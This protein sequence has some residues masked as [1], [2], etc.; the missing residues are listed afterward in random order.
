MSEQSPASDAASRRDFLKSSSALVGATVA[1]GLAAPSVHAAG[2]DVIRIGLIG[3][4]GRGS[5]AA[6]QAMEA[7]SDCKL[8]AMGDVFA[9][10]LVSSRERLRKIGKERFAVE[11]KDCY[12]GLDAYKNVVDCGVDVVLMGTPPGFRPVHLKYAV[13]QGKHVFAEKPVA[14]DGPGVRSVLATC[15]EAK[16]K[17]LSIVSG[18]CWRYHKAV[19]E[20]MQRVQDGQIGRIISLQANYNTRRPRT[21]VPRAEGLSDLEFQLRNWYF[22]AW[23]SGDFNVEQHV[24]TL[25]KMAWVLHDR[26]PVKCIGSGGRQ[27]IAELEPGHIY[28]HHAVHYEFASDDGGPIPCYSYCR[29][30]SGTKSQ[31]EGYVFGTEGKA[32]LLANHLF[33]HKGGTVWKFPRPRR[34]EPRINMYQQEHDELFASIRDGKPINNGEYM[35]HSSLMGIMGR[36]ATYTGQEVTWDQ[37]LNS[38]E[39][40]MPNPT[41]FGAVPEPPIAVPGVTK[42]G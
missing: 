12:V 4:G 8:V 3:C 13:D 1:S 28:D 17:G 16:K 42:L 20:T 21:L 31:T 23:L 19:K 33:D 22:Y 10:K 24:H 7:G 34:D 2:S 30:Q 27:A 5:G 14:V 11:D 36:M 15:A 29:Q 38:E 6:Q 41:E 40:L 26:Y 25:D 9:D 39:V 18:L 37:A 35:A 32:E